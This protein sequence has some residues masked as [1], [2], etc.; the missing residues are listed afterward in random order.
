MKSFNLIDKEWIPC[1]FLNGE[2]R[3]LSI[4]EL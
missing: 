2:S 1:L 4:R 3:N